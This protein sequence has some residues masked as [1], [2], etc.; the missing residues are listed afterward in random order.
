MEMINEA[1]Q[2]DDIHCYRAFI[3]TKMITKE[4]Y[5]K[6]LEIVEYYHYQ[7]NKEIKK[8]ENNLNDIGLKKGDYIY[9]IGGSESQYLTI[10]KKYRLTGEPFRKVVPISNDNGKRMCCN[11]N[12]FSLN[13]L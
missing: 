5:L 8:H 13:A 3:F 1:I 12:W 9:Y 4:E 10:G 2:I 7:L 6:A 11:Q